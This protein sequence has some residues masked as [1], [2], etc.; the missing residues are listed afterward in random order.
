VYR[1]ELYAR[2]WRAVQVKQMSE[3]EAARTFG[4]VRKKLKFSLPPGYRRQAPIRRPK[5]E[6]Y[7]AGIDPILASE[8]QVPRK[9]RHSAKRICERLPDEH[10]YGGGYTVVKGLRARAQAAP[11]GDVRAAPPCPRT[12]AGGFW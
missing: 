8:Q 10:G 1:V 4:L 12:R 9:Q 11:P 2:V 6:V 5:L 7:A 3:R